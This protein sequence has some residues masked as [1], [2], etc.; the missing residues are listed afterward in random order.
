MIRRACEDLRPAYEERGVALAVDAGPEPVWVEA[1]ATRLAQIAGNLL[2]NSLKF[3]PPGGRVRVTLARV[4]DACELRVA[5]TGA[6][7]DPELLEQ[8]FE[9]FAQAERTRGT[10]RGGIGIGLYLVKS[11]VAL[12]GGTVQALSAGSGHGAELVVRLPSSPPPEARRAGG[13]P[14]AGAGHSVLIVED[15]VDAG[16]TLA[17][18]LRLLGHE[19][20]LAFDGA[21]GVSAFRERAPGV[22]LCDVGLPD[23]SGYEVVRR[24]RALPGGG[25]VFAVALTGYAQ[26]EDVQRAL[27]AG[28]D[29]HL[30]KPPSIEQLSRLLAGAARGA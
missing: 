9:P 11:L 16:E 20:R 29:A 22:L 23:T 25:E 30:A 10:A 28:F 4:E 19:P 26:P 2:T 1:D 27:E 3:T 12:H 15:N 5:D 7:I 21:S 18:V 6:G 14:A 8:I 13:A 24:I 17:D